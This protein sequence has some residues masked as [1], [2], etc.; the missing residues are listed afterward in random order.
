MNTEQRDRDDEVKKFPLLGVGLSLALAGATFISGLHM[1]SSHAGQQASLGDLFFREAPVAD[2][3]DLEEFWL[4]WNLL[5]KKFV[6]ASSTDAVTQEERVEGAIQGLV[7]AY[8]DPYT[9][10]LPPKESEQF[11]ED[12]SGNFSG[13]GMEV[14]I[15]D[16]MVTIIAPLPDTPAER[17]GLLSGDIVMRIDG[18]ST[19]GMSIDEAVQLIRGEEGTEVV[20]TIYREGRT[21]LTEVSITRDTIAVPTVR[22][23][24]EGDVFVI[25]LYSFNALAESRM[26]EAL[27][28]YVESGTNK[29]I[30][31]LRSN[32]G[33]YLQSAVSIASYFLPAGEVV[34]REGFG[35]DDEQV[36]RSQGKML[37]EYAPE[38][39]V[40][41]VDQGSAS[42]SEILA[43]A[44]QE[45]GVATL[46]GMKTFGK[47]SVQELVELGTGAS[48]KVTIAR[49]FT[50]EGRS[51]SENGLEPDMVI[52][53][54]FET[55][56]P[57]EDP[58]FD[59][60]LEYLGG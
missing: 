25:E 50:P 34:V 45:H 33:G 11:H 26:Q 40:V 37:G 2:E 60:A 31:D 20:L 43:G 8:G 3:V 7:D 5:E 32:P 51:I 22:T 56:V 4:V 24:T 21:E 58:Q 6:S 49:W 28:E 44:L 53:I 14:G 35:G 46:I 17:A 48:L 18:A 36:Y 19:E 47:G 23:R 59:A 52:P 30:I 57:G 16:K 1:G 27:R 38:K 39:M 12:I 29:I 9:V 15:R 55:L 54:D 41:L 42:A 10:F 13:V